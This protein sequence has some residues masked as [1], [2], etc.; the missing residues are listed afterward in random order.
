LKEWLTDLEAKI[1]SEE[2]KHIEVFE[3]LEIAVI[4]WCL[5]RLQQL[6]AVGI[7]TLPALSRKAEELIVS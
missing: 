3:R 4:A 1:M 6:T 5:D 7:K 2:E